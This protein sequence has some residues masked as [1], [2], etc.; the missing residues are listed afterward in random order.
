MD[1]LTQSPGG[2][3]SSET[4]R[5]ILKERAKLLAKERPVAPDSNEFLHVLEFELADEHYA[6]EMIYIREV[7]P[8]KDLARLPC[9][10]SFVLGVI[11]VRGQIL[12][13]IDIKKFFDL[14]EKGLASLPKAIILHSS[15]MEF[16]VY[17]ENV[18]GVRSIPLKD[19]QPA[20]PTL[21]DIRA[22]Y[23]KGVTEERLIILD[24]SAI[25]TDKN[26]VINEEVQM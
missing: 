26:I 24:A 9:V 14:P 18:T 10:P 5:R 13:I 2:T 22:Q 25:L 4:K 1:N 11:N 15:E 12:S 3:V 17:A 8:I 20:L 19:I 23:L 6:L 16:A 7:F 21:T